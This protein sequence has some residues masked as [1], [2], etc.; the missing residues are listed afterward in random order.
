M[1]LRAMKRRYAS[2]DE[3]RRR[4]NIPAARPDIG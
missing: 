4:R 3:V 1:E 2:V